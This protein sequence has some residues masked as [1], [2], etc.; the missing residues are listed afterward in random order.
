V[1]VSLRR[2]IKQPSYRDLCSLSEKLVRPLD[3]LHQN[4]RVGKR[5]VLPRQVCIE[6][7][8]GP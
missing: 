7:P 5:G 3:E 6:D 8:T 2:G 4:C 1:S